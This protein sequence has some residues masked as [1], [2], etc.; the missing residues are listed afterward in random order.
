MPSNG[1]AAGLSSPPISTQDSTPRDEAI[2]HFYTHNANA[3]AAGPPPHLEHNLAGNTSPQPFYPQQQPQLQ[4]PVAAPP[5]PTSS[6]PSRRS[7]KKRSAAAITPSPTPSIATLSIRNPGTAGTRT[8]TAHTPKPKR[9]MIKPHVTVRQAAQTPLQQQFLSLI[10]AEGEGM[11]RSGLIHSL[12]DAEAKHAQVMLLYAR[13]TEHCTWPSTDPTFP[14]HPAH[15]E[16]YVRQMFYAIWDWHEYGE[17]EKTI[18]PAKMRVRAQALALPE[19][20]PRREELLAQ[21]PLRA[22]QQQKVLGKVLSDFNVQ[23]ICWRLL[24]SFLESFGSF[25]S[26][27]EI[28]KLGKRKLIHC[29]V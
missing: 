12:E 28:A 26:L 29:V 10:K 14:L 3:F 9:R 5:S 16:Q 17:M 20:H 4:I 11:F 24:V 21:L 7:R 2:Q 8:R 18:G 15:Q 27:L 13:P 6:S 1:F 23:M 19:D 22:D 25:S